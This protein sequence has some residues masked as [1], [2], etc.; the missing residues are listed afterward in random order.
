MRRT[1]FSDDLND[2]SLNESFLNASTSAC[3]ARERHA[4]SQELVKKRT[5]STF[6]FP[7]SHLNTLSNSY[8][9]TSTS[10]TFFLSLSSSATPAVPVLKYLTT[11]SCTAPCP[12]ARFFFAASTSRPLILFPPGR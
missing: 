11:R 5:L 2:V 6:F 10:S 4:T 1:G 7:V 12:C 9:V 3:E 8:P